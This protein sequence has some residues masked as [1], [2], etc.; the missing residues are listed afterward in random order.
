M[1]KKH[2][3]I[4]EKVF[5]EFSNRSMFKSKMKMIILTGIILFGTVFAFNFKEGVL[6][7]LGLGALLSLAYFVIVF[8]VMYISTPIIAKKI[9][10]KNNINQYNFDLTFTNE[11]ITQNK[12]QIFPYSMF[13]KIIETKLAFYFYLQERQ[14]IVVGK[15]VLNDE[16]YNSLINIINDIKEIKQ[17]K[18]LKSNKKED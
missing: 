16:E 18:L 13:N 7:S 3:K 11:G 6:Q 4:S 9:Y 14:I 5:V 10:Y 12:D 17:I 15:D 8:G 2:F 1:L